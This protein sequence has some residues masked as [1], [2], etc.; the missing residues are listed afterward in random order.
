M[1]SKVISQQNILQFLLDFDKV[2]TDELFYVDSGNH[3][4]VN[5]FVITSWDALDPYLNNESCQFFVLIDEEKHD[6]IALVKFA[7]TL[8]GSFDKIKNLGGCMYYLEISKKY[9]GKGLLKTVSDEFAKAYP[10][11]VFV[12]NSETDDGYTAHV[13]DHLANSFKNEGLYF[14]KD[15]SEFCREFTHY[16]K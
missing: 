15:N 4:T 11:H 14:Y 7:T 2:S 12:S 8:V 13:N 1:I 3:H 6:V 5:N 9:Q 10:G 16:S